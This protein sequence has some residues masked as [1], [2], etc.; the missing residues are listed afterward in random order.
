MVILLRNVFLYHKHRNVIKNDIFRIVNHGSGGSTV[1]LFDE[2]VG[3]KNTDHTI[4]YFNNYISK[5]PSW[6]R[7]VYL[8]LDNTASTS[9]NY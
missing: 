4:S 6:V 9:K 5:L 7:C 8:F 3:P 2:R 1:Y